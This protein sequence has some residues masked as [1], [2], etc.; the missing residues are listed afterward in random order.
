MTD[1]MPLAYC[2]MVLGGIGLVLAMPR[3]FWN[4]GD[5]D[6]RAMIERMSTVESEEWNRFRAANPH[7]RPVIVR[8]DLSQADYAKMDLANCVITDTSLRGANLKSVSFAGSRLWHVNLADA[9]LTGALFDDADIIDCVMTNATIEPAQLAK[10]RVFQDTA[11]VRPEDILPDPNVRVIGIPELTRDVLAGK[12]Q[13]DQLP[14]WRF[15]ELITLFLLGENR[16]P[17]RIGGEGG[18]NALGA[19]IAK[20]F[21]GKQWLVEYRNLGHGCLLNLTAL[22]AAKRRLVSLQKDGIDVSGVMLLS[23]S[24][25]SDETREEADSE[26]HVELITSERF[27]EGLR[28]G[29]EG[30]MY[31]RL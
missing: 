16:N 14:T 15:D 10:A 29:H 5:R 25:F 9:D 3:L 7:Q 22:R 6:L 26:D 4:K 21:D 24:G 17:N 23:P 19:I 1:L 31:S 20:G 11:Q 2:F 28:K 13:C 8:Q 27:F 18:Q 12:I 30:N